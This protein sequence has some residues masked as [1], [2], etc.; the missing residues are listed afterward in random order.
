M[1]FDRPCPAAIPRQQTR[2]KFPTP[3]RKSTITNLIH[4]TVF[5]LKGD[6]MKI[7]A[8]ISLSFFAT[9]THAST[10]RCDRV[11]T[12][13]SLAHSAITE[14]LFNGY[15]TEG[16]PFS[17]NGNMGALYKVKVYNPKTNRSRK[18]LFKP[19]FFGDGNGWNRTPMEYVAY[20]V[21]KML[22]MDL[23]PPVAYRRNFWING[24]HFSEGA[25][26]YMVPD[27]HNLDQ[28]SKQKWGMDSEIFLSDTQVL[29][30]LLQNPD[31]HIH[32][33]IRGQH[34]TDGKYRPILIDHGSMMRKQTRHKMTS[35]G[36]FS[37]TAI[38]KISEKTWLGLKG[39]NKRKLKTLSEFLS[40]EEMDQILAR[41]DA[42]V[43]YFL[44]LPN[45]VV[46]LY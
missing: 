36:P 13:N 8:L 42:I 38:E 27:A 10:V 16:A 24:T 44:N 23:V 39:L 20:E 37:S 19:R 15:V 9:I 33:F 45:S 7:L 29:D 21:N 28:V 14:D 43:S 5:S 3:I 30:V 25:L 32:N 46:P 6:V 26:L 2:K 11:V 4:G 35:K 12:K 31:R 22:G 41:R 18:A 1:P 17:A 40:S 34:W